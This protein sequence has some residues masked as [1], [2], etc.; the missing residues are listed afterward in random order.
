MLNRKLA[1]RQGKIFN[2]VN[3][4]LKNE[5]VHQCSQILSHIQQA[6]M[7]LCIHFETK[8]RKRND[9][10]CKHYYNKKKKYI[11]TKL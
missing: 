3:I 2:T 4:S 5:T 8:E 1:G 9:E 10:Y 7:T 6:N 11:H